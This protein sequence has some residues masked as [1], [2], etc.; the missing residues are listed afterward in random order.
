MRAVWKFPILEPVWS[1]LM[2]E[3][4]K[5]VHVH[6]QNNKPCLW[7]EVD[8]EAPKK[9]RSFHA[10]MTGQEIPMDDGLSYVGTAHLHSG[11]IVAHVYEKV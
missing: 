11:Q 1:V 5:I 3:G 10:F 6:A 9:V 4:S 7:V 8:S 2:P